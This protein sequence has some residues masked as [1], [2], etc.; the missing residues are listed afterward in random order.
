MKRFEYK[1]L[2]AAVIEPHRESEEFDLKYKIICPV[3]TF[4][5]T[6]SS[7]SS[8]LPDKCLSIASCCVNATPT[9]HQD[10]ITK[11]SITFFI[12]P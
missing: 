11:I 4:D 6:P 12:S 9:V 3:S 2:D 10:T 5:Q 8:F 7:V 1:I